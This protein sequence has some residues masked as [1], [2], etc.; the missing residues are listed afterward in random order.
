MKSLEHAESILVANAVSQMEH[1]ILHLADRESPKVMVLVDCE[2]LSPFKLPM[3]MIRSCSLL[4]QDHFPHCLGGLYVI[5]LPP[6]IR[7]MVQTFKKVSYLFHY[8]W[9]V[10]FPSQI[11]SLIQLR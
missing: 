6:V 8:C 1:G 11:C 10:I 5:R 9:N 2:G 7:V 4:F 3:Q